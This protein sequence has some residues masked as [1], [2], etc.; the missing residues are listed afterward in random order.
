MGA[1]FK[2]LPT[3]ISTPVR[4]EIIKKNL[5]LI[6]DTNIKITEINAPISASKQKDDIIVENL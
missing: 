4:K 6:Y 2:K 1:C 5:N 3:S